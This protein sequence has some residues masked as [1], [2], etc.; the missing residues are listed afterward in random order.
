MP[1]WSR[2]RVQT[3]LGVRAPRP[4]PRRVGARAWAGPGAPGPRTA[5]GTV[6]GLPGYGQRGRARGRRSR[7]SLEAS[8]GRAPAPVFCKMAFIRLAHTRA[9]QPQYTQYRVWRVPL[10]ISTRRCC[11]DA[12][13]PPAVPGSRV[14]T[15]HQ[16]TTPP[17]P[18]PQHGLRALLSWRG[19]THAGMGRAARRSQLGTSRLTSAAAH[20]IVDSPVGPKAVLDRPSSPQPRSP[21]S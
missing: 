18:Q 20:S 19:K 8:R 5:L 1:C 4:C 21:P 13:S 15:A 6:R 7:P 2:N 17:A 12:T 3:A 9:A 10:R 14:R 11:R 16:P